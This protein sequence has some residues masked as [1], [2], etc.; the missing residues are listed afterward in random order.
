MTL[1]ARIFSWFTPFLISL[2]LGIVV[3]FSFR[4]SLFHPLLLLFVLYLLPPLVYRLHDFFWPVKAGVFP[5]EDGKYLP[6]WGSY[7]I[8][9]I[10]VVFPSL[11]KIL[12]VFPGFYSAWLRLWGSEIGK[13]VFWTPTVL[14]ADRAFLKIE[15]DVIFGHEVVCFPHLI[16]PKKQVEQWVLH[17]APIS[18]GR[19]SFLGGQARLGPGCRIEEKTWLPIA[20]DVRPYATYPDKNEL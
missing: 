13:R 15:N 3:S 2:S 12:R 14:I 20:T 11:E 4:P 18:I 5:F 16:K 6:W 9:S 8:Q 10:Y 17:L 7:E 1:Q 19:A